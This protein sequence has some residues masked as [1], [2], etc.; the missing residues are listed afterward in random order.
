MLSSVRGSVWKDTSRYLNV[1]L[2]IERI[3]E[4]QVALLARDSLLT[5]QEANR[6]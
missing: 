6:L 5:L 3:S 2:P 1:L 4:F